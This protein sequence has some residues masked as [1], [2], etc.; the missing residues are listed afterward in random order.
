MSLFTVTQHNNVLP[1]NPTFTNESPIGCSDIHITQTTLLGRIS[2]PRQIAI[3]R[4]ETPHGNM[5]LTGQSTYIIHDYLASLTIGKTPS[6]QL[7]AVDV[8][9]LPTNIE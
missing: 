2:H 3:A 5:L 6:L 4:P 9:L 7:L 8:H 1:K